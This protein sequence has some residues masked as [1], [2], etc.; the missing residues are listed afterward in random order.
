MDAVESLAAPAPDLDLRLLLFNLLP[1][2]SFHPQRWAANW[3]Q[4]PAL[5]RDTRA[6]RR[7][8]RH[9]SAGFLRESDTGHVST[10]NDPMLPVFLTDDSLFDA[11][12]GHLG[13]VILGPAIR[14]VI[15]QDEVKALQKALQ[16]TGLAFARREA[17]TLWDGDP[18]ADAHVGLSIESVGPQ[19]QALGGALLF[20]AALSASAPVCARGQVRLAPSAQEDCLHLPASLCDREVAAALALSTLAFLNPSWLSVFPPS[21]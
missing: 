3:P 11:L 6:A 17:R 15:A 13:L 18:S 4:N 10:L 2:R 12:R 21:T 9:V 1:S 8:H 16:P 5:A 19:A 14:R 7:L 20:M